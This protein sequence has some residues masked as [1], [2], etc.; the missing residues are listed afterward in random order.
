[1]EAASEIFL[2][3][4]AKGCVFFMHTFDNSFDIVLHAK[5]GIYVSLMS[6]TR[7][8]YRKLINPSVNLDGEKLRNVT[9]NFIRICNRKKK[10]YSSDQSP[11]E[12]SFRTNTGET[13]RI[14][15]YLNKAS[16]LNH[17]FARRI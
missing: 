11:L 13:W 17:S 14:C 7:V 2:I 4:I 8:G 15:V 12:L 5:M 3:F 1:M 10:I 16:F 6:F 9:Q